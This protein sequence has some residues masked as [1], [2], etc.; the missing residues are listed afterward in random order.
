MK[1]R[2]TILTA[3]AAILAAAVTSCAPFRQP[4]IELA[5]VR[6]AGL[7][8]TGGTINVRLAVQNPNRYALRAQ[9]LTYELA[10]GEPGGGADQWI[11][12]AS[13]TF[14]DA[15]EVAGRDSA[16]IDIPV[17]FSY[18][19]AGTAIRSII[20]TGSF[21]YRVSGTVQVTG[22]VRRQV[23]YAR[24]GVVSMDSM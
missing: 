11:E 24:R 5:S 7:G 19:G 6:L 1:P 21:R 15:L 13:G 3:L 10:L 4:E 23:P 20:E 16:L 18:R 12:F 2:I 8:L 22:P 9:G 14:T 17:E